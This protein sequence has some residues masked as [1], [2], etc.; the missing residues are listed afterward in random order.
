MLSIQLPLVDIITS[1]KAQYWRSTLLSETISDIWKPFKR[2]EKCFLFHV[3]SSF[4]SQ[5]ICIFVLT[6]WFQNLW[7]RRQ[8][9]YCLTS[10]VLPNITRNKGNQAIEFDQLINYNVRNSF[11]QKSCR[12]REREREKERERERER[13]TVS[14]SRP[15]F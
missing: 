9:A 2:D 6:F 7:S 11:L 13:E 12:K 4:C 15:L 3:K 8:Y 1:L 5:G 10:R 14:R